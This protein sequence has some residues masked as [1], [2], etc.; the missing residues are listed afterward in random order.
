M[1][2]RY[3]FNMLVR[4][5]AILLCM[6]RTVIIHC[7]L[8]RLGAHEYGGEGGL[9]SPV[10]SASDHEA[11]AADLISEVDSRRP[12]EAQLDHNVVSNKRMGCRERA[13]PIGA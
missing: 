8:P 3:S 13:G 12:P 1:T 4:E 6:L 11:I 5:A 2:C 7:K 9:A 10:A